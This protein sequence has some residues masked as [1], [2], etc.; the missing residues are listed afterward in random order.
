MHPLEQVSLKPNKDM[1][2]DR[3]RRKAAGSAIDRSR[4]ANPPI[5]LKFKDHNNAYQPSGQKYIRYKRK[6]H[7]W[8]VF[9]GS[10]NNRKKKP[11]GRALIR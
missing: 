10:M 5:S 9:L 8:G 4:L 7:R 3:N 11:I 6:M 2:I 1:L